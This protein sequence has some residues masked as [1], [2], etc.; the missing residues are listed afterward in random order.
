M[1]L[2]V[3]HEE[4]RPII[5]NVAAAIQA[6][7]ADRI[8]TSWTIA[9]CKGGYVVNAYIADGVDC[10][11]GARELDIVYDVSPLRILSAATAR[12]GGKFMVRVRISDR[13]E[14]IMLTEVTIS[15][16]RKRSRWM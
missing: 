14:P 2:E 9:V 11:F 3:V 16:V 5:R 8:F 6:L 7:K 4:D 1:D 12:Q 15:H 13:N 10:E